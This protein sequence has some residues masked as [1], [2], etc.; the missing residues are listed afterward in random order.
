MGEPE[1]KGMADALLVEV[2]AAEAS[3]Q[4][5]DRRPDEIAP[6]T[7]EIKAHAA[8]MQV[9]ER[10]RHQAKQFVPEAGRSEGGSLVA[11]TSLV[12]I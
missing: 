12:T 5:P 1:L 6:W 11:P 10:A 9:P 3:P 8:L 2:L 7:E 4:K